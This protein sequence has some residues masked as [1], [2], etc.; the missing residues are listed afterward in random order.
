MI[1][2]LAALVW[3]PVVESTPREQ[4]I[5]FRSE[6]HTEAQ[7]R[8]DEEHVAMLQDVAESLGLEWRVQDLSSGAPADVRLTPLL[9]HQNSSGRSIYQGRYT[10]RERIENFVR[11][12]RW[13]PQ[14]P[15]PLERESVFVRH[16]GRTTIAIQPKVTPLAGRALGE[17]G[18]PERDAFEHGAREAI[19][20]GLRSF[21]SAKRA[22][23]S[24][25]DRTFYF[26]FHPYRSDDGELFVSGA[27]FSQFDCDVPIFTTFDSPASSPWSDSAAAFERAAADLEAALDEL[28]ATSDRGD[29]FSPVPS[30]TP[31]RGWEE[32][33]LALPASTQ[34]PED[35]GS[36][37]PR[38][39]LA[40]QW[41]LLP[42][43]PDSGPRLQFRFPPPLDSYSGELRDVTGELRFER[44]ATD[45]GPEARSLEGR[46]VVRVASITMG[47]EYLDDSLL[48]PD[49][50]DADRHPESSFEVERIETG[51]GAL[52][53][54]ELRPATLFGTFRMKGVEIPLSTTLTLE[55]VAT[56]E[57]DV[58]LRA[59]GRFELRLAEA[60]GIQG[61]DGPSPANDTLQFRYDLEYAPIAPE[62]KSN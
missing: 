20:R 16:V 33:G 55:P 47:D 5:L 12:A 23:L 35:D 54:G 31:L 48:A 21:H 57:G 38:S 30:E 28:L 8:F 3:I 53:F 29:A 14:E 7:R 24:R 40:T 17:D 49:T 32:L 62:G 56:A 45:R 36:A 52:R 59:R 34:Q 25:S 1:T 13:F 46:V 26:D 9:V 18:D 58:R 43:T 11:T 50:L 39:A 10:H 44:A 41:R 61:P 22:Q 2:L 42:R 4:L 51:P 37:R 60:F 27:I 6:P 19:D 15:I